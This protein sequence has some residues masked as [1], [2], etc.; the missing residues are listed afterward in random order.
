MRLK[1]LTIFYLITFYVL[2]QFTWWSYLLIIYYP[3]RLRM[4]V[5][6]GLVFFAI[7]SVG[8][9]SLHRSIKRQQLI[10]QQQKNFL[11]SITHELKSPI[12]SIKL[13]LETI[14][15]R[16]LDAEKR[17]EFLENALKD[18]NRLDDLVENVL[19]ATKI[20]NNSYSFP[21][22]QINL[23]NLCNEISE[24]YTQAYGSKYSF[25]SMIEKNLTI[26]GDRFTL[27]IAI[28]NLLE[29][30][31]KYSAKSAK[32]SFLLSDKMDNIVLSIMD[33][34][35]GIPNSEKMNIFK[36]FYRIGNEETRQTKGTGLGLFIVKNILDKHKAEITVNDNYPK[37]SIFQIEFK[38]H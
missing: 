20:E 30:A 15:K 36:R 28:N 4:W 9:Y 7:L 14:L 32:I 26:M 18:T 6:E 29:N 11:L 37:G 38:K 35:K 23:S 12:A 19:I 10:A 5:G 31:M 3:E 17:K 2:L 8:A 21:K 25:E 16:N 22:E 24:R 13:F 34:G 33:E 1:P 27:G